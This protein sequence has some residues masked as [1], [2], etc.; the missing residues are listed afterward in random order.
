MTYG[1]ISTHIENVER[2]LWMRLA[3]YPISREYCAT[4][5]GSPTIHTKHA[6]ILYVSSHH[7]RELQHV[8][9]VYNLNWAKSMQE[10]LIKI[11]E[12]KI[13]TGDKL[14]KEVADNYRKQYRQIL[15]DGESESPP[16]QPLLLIE[17]TKKRGKIKKEKHRN[18]L[19][20]LQNFEDDVLRFM[21]T[22]FV[23]FTNNLGEND[24][25]MTKVH[26]K[27]SGCFRSEEGA[28][29]FCRIRSYLLTSQKHGVNPSEALTLLFDGK[30]PE[31]CGIDSGMAE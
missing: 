7:I 3:S 6:S 13:K 10:L 23:P 11:N 24:I 16:P 20:R 19:E 15:K 26:Q 22:D 4:T 1:C 27:I 12:E 9:D 17:G 8:I 14:T 29:I 31:F 2:K 28:K 5:T 30:L 25:R 21:E 18:L